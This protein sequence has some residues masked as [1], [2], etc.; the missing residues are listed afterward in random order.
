MASAVSYLA[1]SGAAY[2]NGHTLAV[3]GGLTIS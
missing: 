3:D 2:V 1:S